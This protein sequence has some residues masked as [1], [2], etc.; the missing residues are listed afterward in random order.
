MNSGSIC[1]CGDKM[2][3]ADPGCETEFLS[4]Q[5]VTPSRNLLSYPDSPYA[6]IQLICMFSFYIST[7][8]IAPRYNK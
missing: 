6:E 3:A 8:Q 5:S 2:K 7:L 4:A 1:V